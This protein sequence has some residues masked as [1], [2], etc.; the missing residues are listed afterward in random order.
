M[1]VLPPLV[2]CYKTC[3]NTLFPLI[4]ALLLRLG[5]FLPSGAA[6][7][8]HCTQ[9]SRLF[10]GL[11]CHIIKLK[12]GKGSAGTN[13]PQQNLR[14]R[15]TCL[16]GL[17]VYSYLMSG[18][19]TSLTSYADYPRDLCTSATIQHSQDLAQAQFPTCSWF[20]GPQSH[21]GKQ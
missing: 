15:K 14:P 4:T 20:K 19:K 3:G 12:G 21:V 11:G 8:S 7:Q 6:T 5:R 17:W 16:Y 18:C 10:D 9:I 13:Q 2:Q 1:P